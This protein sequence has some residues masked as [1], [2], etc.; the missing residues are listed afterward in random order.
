MVSKFQ[1]SIATQKKRKEVKTVLVL[2]TFYFSR[3]IPTQ[4][5]RSQKQCEPYLLFIFLVKSLTCLILFP[6]VVY[7]AELSKIKTKKDHT[8][9][10]YNI[11]VRHEE[12]WAVKLRKWLSGLKKRQ[13][14]LVED[15]SWNSQKKG[16]GHLSVEIMT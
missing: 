13:W 6:C 10:S 15:E 3:S 7:S 4:K 9:L 14:L 1:L 16:Y 11:N 8:E 12:Q 5:K 2:L